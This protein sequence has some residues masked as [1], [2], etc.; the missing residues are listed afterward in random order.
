M[1]T[2]EQHIKNLQRYLTNYSQHLFYSEEQKLFSA[3]TQAVDKNGKIFYLYI[4]FTYD[5]TNGHKLF[6]VLVK[7]I[8]EEQFKR[9]EANAK[10]SLSQSM[11]HSYNPVAVKY[12]K[13]HKAFVNTIKN[14]VSQ[15]EVP[16]QFDWQKVS[17]FYTKILTLLP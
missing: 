14:L 2:Q 10:F 6:N 11:C 7:D 5:E 8:A 12:W 16:S 17:T 3:L 4:F 1:K 13:T 9:H 15:C